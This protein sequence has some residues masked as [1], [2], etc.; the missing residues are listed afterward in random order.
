MLILMRQYL[1]CANVRRRP[2]Q[3]FCF[4]AVFVVVL[5]VV[6]VVLVVVLVVL[7]VVVCLF[8]CLLACLFVC[9]LVLYCFFKKKKTKSKNN[10]ICIRKC[11]NAKIF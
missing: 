1:A 8:A 11:A 3:I 10:L 2:F 6:L 4:T 5:V 9:L 7:V